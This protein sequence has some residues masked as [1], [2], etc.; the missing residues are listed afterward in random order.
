MLWWVLWCFCVCAKRNSSR[1]LRKWWPTTCC[2]D[3]QINC[4]DDKGVLLGNWKNDYEGGVS[5]L[6]WRGSVEILRNWDAQS[7]EP[8]RYGQCWVFAAV[9]CTGES[10]SLT[11]IWPFSNIYHVLHAQYKDQHASEY[12]WIHR[13]DFYFLS[14]SR[15]L[16][17]PCRVIT[18]YLSAHDTNNN[19]VIERFVNEKGELMQS[20]DMV[21]WVS[22]GNVNVR[23]V[24]CV[25]WWTRKQTSHLPLA[26]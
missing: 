12:H 7:C 2:F 11:L 17:I 18:N 13:L 3:F 1:C 10:L 6:S 15:A 20:R 9:A 24:S 19:L 4:N 26:H 8:V 5:P 16:G 22:G 23:R 21:W 14:V 25:G